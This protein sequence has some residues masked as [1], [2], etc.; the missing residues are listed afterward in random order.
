MLV[1][2]TNDVFHFDFTH[3]GR[4]IRR[5]VTCA[6]LAH[7]LEGGDFANPDANLP[8]GK[9]PITF[10]G[11][12]AEYYLPMHCKP[13]KKGGTSRTDKIS[14][15]SLARYFGDMTLHSI[16]P[17]HWEEY[18]SLRLAG[19]VPTRCGPIMEETLR[20]NDR[21]GPK[22]R[23]ASPWTV[24]RELSCMNQIFVY[25]ARLQFVKANPMLGAARLPAQSRKDFW[26]KKS[27]IDP[28]LNSIPLRLFKDNPR[29]LR[30]L[31]EFLILTGARIGEG[32]LFNE[33]DVDRGR[34]EIRVITFKKK[35]AR[36]KAYRYLSIESL[37]P[38]FSSLLKGMRPHPSTGYYFY[39]ANGRGTPLPYQWARRQLVSGA[40][41]A[42]LNWLRPHDMRHTFAMHRAIVIRDFRKLQMELGHEDPVSVQSYLDNTARLD[43]SDSV[44]H[45]AVTAQ[46]PFPEHPLKSTG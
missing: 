3:G 21:R 2:K 25:A 35:K 26:L 22:D 36:E 19:K 42:G 45:A 43:P 28:Y 40:R 24:N 8:P 10:Y 32:L 38:R 46:G 5:V 20:R 14:A 16:E 6:E 29:Q 15:R 37:G 1:T 13:N 34:G 41:K 7:F 33:R 17:R 4:R 39:G 11:F 44:F 23:P 30:H 31:A 18:K 9:H 12:V 27:E